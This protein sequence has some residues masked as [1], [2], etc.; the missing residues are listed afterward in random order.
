[1][2]Y[3][4]LCEKIWDGSPSTQNIEGGIESTEI[5]AQVDDNTHGNMEDFVVE[6]LSEIDYNDATTDI[7]DEAFGSNQNIITKRRELL[8][9]K[10]STYKHEQMKRKLPV[11]T[12]LL[13]CAQEELA[14]KKL[15]EQ[16]DTFQKQYSETMTKLLDNMDKLTNSISEGFSVWSISWSLRHQHPMHIKVTI[17]NV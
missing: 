13:W 16:M 7:T 2:L 6:T 3:N 10:L 12:Q 8:D 14:I 5:V 15:V 4:E 9:G 17:N 11:D 1:M